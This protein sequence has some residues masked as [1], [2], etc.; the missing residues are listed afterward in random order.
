MWLWSQRGTKNIW[1]IY[2]KLW[3]VQGG[4]VWR[5]TQINAPLVYQLVNSWVSWCMI[6][7]LR[8]VRKLSQLSTK[9]KPRRRKLNFNHWSARL[10]LSGGSYL[11][12]LQ[13]YVFAC[14]FLATSLDIVYYRLNV[15][16]WVL[17][18]T[19]DHFQASTWSENHESLH[20]LHA[21]LSNKVPK[22]HFT[23]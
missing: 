13:D 1:L 11:I 22:P 5:W 9:L 21:S 12:Y 18:L 2:V 8:L 23:S 19:N 4:M 15:W 10:T 3:S 14:I 16:L 20:F 6:E 17:T 7:G